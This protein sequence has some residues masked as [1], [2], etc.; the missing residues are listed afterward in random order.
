MKIRRMAASLILGLIFATCVF[1]DGFIV[2]HPP[3]PPRPTPVPVP[4]QP[5]PH[6]FAPLVV[7]YHKVNVDISDQ[8]A[9]T[10]VDQ[11][12]HN[13][14]PNRLEGTFIFPLP[15]HSQID[16]FSM[17]INGRQV[18]AE[19]L[20]ADKARKIYEDIVRRMKDPA[21]LEY[22][23]RGAFKVRIYPIEPRSDKRIKLAYTQILKSDTGL[24]EYAYPLNTER[25]S[26]Q[27][28]ETVSINAS[29]K[30]ANPL[31][32]V[33]SPSHKIETS[34]QGENR[35]TV[36]FEENNAKPDTDFILYFSAARDRKREIG[37]NLM[38]FNP[39][40][41]EDGHFLLIASPG[42]TA[43]RDNNV[44]EKDAVF[45]LDT[46]GS[47]HGPK[48]AQAKRALRYC[49]T[50]LN[51][52][53]RFE[54]IRFSTEAEAMFGNLVK[55]EPRN[56]EKAETMIENFK[57]RGGTAI[58]E[59]LVAAAGF[60]KEKGDDIRP[61]HG[62]PYY[63]IFLTDGRPTIGVTDDG[64]IL[65]SL[66]KA[67]GDRKVRMFCFGIGK[68]IN[69]HLLDNIAEKT[70]AACQYVLPDEDIEVKVSNFY[71]RIDNPVLANTRLETSGRVKLVQTHPADLPDL[72][73]G[74][75]LVLAGR[76]RGHGD[77]AL[78]LNGMFN[79]KPV[80]IVEETMFPGPGRATENT[81]VPR[82]WAVRRVGYLLDQIRLH[83]SDRELVDE[84]TRLAKRY[85]IVTP[86]TSY[87][88]LEDE[89][90]PAQG[91]PPRRLSK[92]GPGEAEHARGELRNKFHAFMRDDSG[93]S[94]IGASKSASAMKMANSAPSAVADADRAA[95]LDGS[96]S[97]TM[98][99]SRFIRGRT[100]YFTGEEWVDAEAANTPENKFIK[101]EFGS[102]AYFQLLDK[103]PDAG[104]WLSIGL[105]LRVKIGNDWYFVK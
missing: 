80:K 76:Y 26:A 101:I 86:Y 85:G 72:F 40:D 18:E 91:P 90:R 99:I 61:D 4:P 89:S 48:L 104:A 51:P 10:K 56:L 43:A 96:E 17:D 100:F 94:G 37:L 82:L 93:Y 23:G 2:V 5:R 6:A 84:A 87:L 33:Y 81:F 49:V 24:V 55:S 63:V 92:I 98:Q 97:E 77:A 22:A 34:R 95:R 9:A 78:V 42:L 13:P 83:G 29:V 39:D 7:K 65:K 52:G 15:K 1:A 45:V 25:F 41:G 8:V 57:P 73:R 66:S 68:D 53:D 74:D 105:P 27:P 11:V 88:I 70:K 38:A 35:A 64:E 58:E 19:L 102:D 32:S 67:V 20:D 31:K 36:R 47:M 60:A 12:F 30:T 28:I 46:S 62:R 71:E 59:A 54:I 14:N 16:R 3:R 69:T 103:H 50:N 21:L 44:V 79:G 75:Q